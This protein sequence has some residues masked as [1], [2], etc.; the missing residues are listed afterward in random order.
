MTS[1]SK[2]RNAANMKFFLAFLIAALFGASAVHASNQAT[3]LKNK[4]NIYTA[5]QSFCG[6]NNIVVPS[7]YANAGKKAGNKRVFVSKFSLSTPKPLWIFRK[8]DQSCQPALVAQPSGCLR[9]TADRNCSRC[10]RKLLRTATTS[11]TLVEMAAKNSL[12]GAASSHR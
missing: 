6:R 3:C 2:C 1:P 12:L 11:S 9:S 5:I 10:V 8:T 7:P 4:P